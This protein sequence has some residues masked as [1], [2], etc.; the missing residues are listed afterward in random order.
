MVIGVEKTTVY[1]PAELQIALREAARRQDRTV[2]DLVRE[3]LE[4]YLRSQ[5]RP[6]VTSVGLG[7]DDELTGA[8]S[9]AYLRAHW[10]R[11]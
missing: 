6:T 10:A 3:A 7:E 8:D 1:L 2:A 4:A 9:E 5:S 11:T